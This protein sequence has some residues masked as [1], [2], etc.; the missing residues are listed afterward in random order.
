MGPRG[1]TLMQPW[2][3][4]A[5]P[6]STG[7]VRAN[8]LARSLAASQLIS[9]YCRFPGGAPPQR[10]RLPEHRPWCSP[11]RFDCPYRRPTDESTPPLTP[12]FSAAGRRSPLTL[13]AVT[14][15]TD[16]DPLYPKSR[17]G[18][19]EIRQPVFGK[20]RDKLL[21]RETLYTLRG[22]EVLAERHRRTYNRVRPM[23]ATS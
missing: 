16:T 18:R 19:T 20:L 12:R 23:L 14:L 22:V 11:V 4:P 21:D 13:P 17:Q 10:L 2:P 8:T 9:K 5:M 15:K 6:K 3:Q 1:Q 7:S